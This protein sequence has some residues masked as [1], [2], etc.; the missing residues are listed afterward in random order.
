MNT[1]FFISDLNGNLNS[2]KLLL[3]VISSKKPDFVFIVGNLINNANIDL[4]DGRTSAEFFA[5]F[6]F[7]E[8]S[9]LKALMD[10]NY[11]EIF[12]VPSIEDQKQMYTTI[13][14]GEKADLW[15]NF[16]NGCFVI[17]KYRFYGLAFSASDVLIEKTNE[18]HPR[19]NKV[20]PKAQESYG[21]F[22]KDSSEDEMFF[23]ES[24]TRILNLINNDD[25]EYGIFL[26]HM[27]CNSSSHNK[28]GYKDNT[29]A[30]PFAK[31]VNDLICNKNPYIIMNNELHSNSCPKNKWKDKLGRTMLFS[32]SHDESHLAI[33]SFELHNPDLATRKLYII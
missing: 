6:L 1:C 30:S 7:T 33:I 27:S 18:Q 21:F 23:N 19:P 9:S 17:G 8:F 28:V 20:L 16:N 24:E 25:L 2:F 26:F 31:V 13:S 12:L 22:V 32:G 11:P 4:A 5:N 10:C 14:V 3:K 15:R 29:L